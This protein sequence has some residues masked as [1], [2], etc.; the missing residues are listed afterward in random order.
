M[1]TSHE[2][3]EVGSTVESTVC[4]DGTN[5]LRVTNVGERIGLQQDEIRELAHLDRSQRIGKPQ[6][7][8]G[9]DRRRSQSLQWR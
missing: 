8:R 9:I 6:H 5:P 2:P 1:P 7:A 4:H 3:I